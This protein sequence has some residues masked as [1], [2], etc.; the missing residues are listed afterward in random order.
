MMGPDG[1]LCYIP[2]ENVAAAIAAGGRVMTAD[3]M[4][5]LRQQVFMEHS[6]FQH[7]RRPRNEGKRRRK[8]LQIRSAR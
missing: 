4:R 8:G 2:E 5:A 6:L 3:D 7:E 1:H